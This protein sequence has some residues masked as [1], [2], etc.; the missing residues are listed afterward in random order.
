MSEAT[1]TEQGSPEPRPSATV[2]T[3]EM[4]ERGAKALFADYDRL[5]NPAR[6]DEGPN[7]WDDAPKDAC[8]DY[9]NSARAV[10]EAALDQ[11]EKDDGKETT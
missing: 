3:D 10:L 9:T 6:D 1:T 2:I 11:A 5:F 7:S 4:V 8:D